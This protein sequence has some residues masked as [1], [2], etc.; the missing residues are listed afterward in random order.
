MLR[1]GLTGGIGAGKSTVSAALAERGLTIVDG[2]L[3]A[4]EVVAPGGG[5]YQGLIE[6]FGRHILRPDGTLDRK[7]L[8]ALV[9]PDKEKV[10]RLNAITHPAIRATVEERVGLAEAQGE[11]MVVLDMPLLN[12][13]SVEAFG[14]GFVVVVDVPTEVA[15]ERLVTARGF[16]RADAEARVASQMNREERRAIADLVIDNTGTPEQLAGQI[17]S[18][19]ERLRSVSPPR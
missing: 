5:A 11:A 6:E 19:W 2:D 3:I 12:R 1:V 10:A 8:A 17:D 7:G 18:L 4:R 15:I 13:Q 16:E 14:M 9:F